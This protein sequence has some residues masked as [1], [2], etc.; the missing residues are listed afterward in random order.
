MPSDF[1]KFFSVFYPICAQ[2]ATPIICCCGRAEALPIDDPFSAAEAGV[3]AVG[4][5]EISEASVRIARSVVSGA[6]VRA[7]VLPG[8]GVSEVDVV[9]ND[10][11]A[12]GFYNRS[13]ILSMTDSN[14]LCLSSGTL[15]S[16][17]AI[18]RLGAIER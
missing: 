11:R 15:A 8:L 17:E 12:A 18:C 7:T 10:F 4:D 2:K 6:A 5:A 16:N 3:K 13:T 9:R 14:C 1:S